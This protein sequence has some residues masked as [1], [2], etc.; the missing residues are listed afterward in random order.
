MEKKYWHEISDE[1]AQRYIESGA[2]WCDIDKDYKKP[3]WCKISLEQGCYSLFYDKTRHEIKKKGKE[4]CKDC[5][6][7]KEV[8]D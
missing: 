8:E 4:Y 3:D 5:D 7:Y 2:K 1:E 6:F